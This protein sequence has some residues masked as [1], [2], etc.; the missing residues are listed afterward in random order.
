MLFNNPFFYDIWSNWFLHNTNDLMNTIHKSGRWRLFYQGP[1]Y[2]YVSLY[3]ILI[4]DGQPSVYTVGMVCTPSN[5]H[6]QLYEIN[7]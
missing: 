6:R 2:R 5:V 7:H 3:F 1:N 4:Q